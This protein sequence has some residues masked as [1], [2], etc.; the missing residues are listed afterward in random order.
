MLIAIHFRTLLCLSLWLALLLMLVLLLVL[1]LV[2]VV[3]LLAC[4]VHVLLLLLL[5]G[6][7]LVHQ[8][9]THIQTATGGGGRGV[10]GHVA[11]LSKLQWNW[12]TRPTSRVISR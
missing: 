5:H 1:L 12:L 3:V 7:H 11:I 6:G 9:I 4:E 8:L 2:L 10:P